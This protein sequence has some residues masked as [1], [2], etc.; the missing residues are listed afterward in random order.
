MVQ[1]F[2]QAPDPGQQS[3]LNIGQAFGG[4]LSQGLSAG[5]Q[6]FLEQKK[7][8]SLLGN[9]GIGTPQASGVGQ[10]GLEPQ[11]SAGLRNVRPEQILAL[12]TVNPQLG[13]VLSN[14]YA[15]EQK[16]FEKQR[17]YES[18]RSSKYLDKISDM[19]I[20]LPERE[21]AIESAISAVKSGQIKPFGGDFVADIFN[22]PQL[23]TASG[24]QLATAAK[25]NLIGSLS[26]VTGG[27][28]NQFIEQQINNAFAKAGQTEE[29]NL[30]QLEIIKSKLDIDKKLAEATDQLADEY[31]SRLGY[32]PESIDRDARK[33]VKPY[34][35]QRLK[36]LAYDLR[37]NMEK[38]LGSSKIKDLK[39]VPTGTPLTLRTA[40]I[41]VDKYGDQAEEVAIKLGYDIPE[42]EV[43]ARK[44]R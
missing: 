42:P 11:S 33:L 14:L 30:S 4:G 43:Y 16:T 2:Q 20:N 37:E 44:I 22:L 15:T 38:E 9:I 40:K 24:A 32:V 23:R 17:A 1:F 27:R 8:Q 18:D 34:A 10:K 25:T 26:Q 29:A 28:P 6:Q 7:I 41:L 21:A 31:R 12:S 19:A 5:L 35:D 13:N 39:K 36:E 3:A